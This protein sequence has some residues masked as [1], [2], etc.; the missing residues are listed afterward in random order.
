MQYL[1]VLGVLYIEI[2][3]DEC[4][5]DNGGCEHNCSNTEGSYYCYCQSGYSLM[6]DGRNC[7][8]RT[9]IKCFTEFREESENKMC[10]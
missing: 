6:I 9:I 7:T 10:F 5:T 1:T 3:I 4:T 8:G 2:D